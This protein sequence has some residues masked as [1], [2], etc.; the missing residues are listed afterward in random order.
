[1]RGV[2]GFSPP[3]PL[4]RDTTE[5]DITP[6]IHRVFHLSGNQYVKNSVTMDDS[7]KSEN[8]YDITLELTDIL[9]QKTQ[10]KT[11]TYTNDRPPNEEFEIK[12]T[13]ES[14]RYNISSVTFRLKCSKVD[15]SSSVRDF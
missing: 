3:F 11:Y 6:Q 1:M 2:G 4:Q 15:H 10:S 12:I 14:L 5:P 7:K 9:T 8:K 13:L